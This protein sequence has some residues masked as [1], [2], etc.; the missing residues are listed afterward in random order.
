MS[1]PLL[2]GVLAMLMMGNNFDENV[3]RTESKMFGCISM[4]N[5]DDESDSL[6]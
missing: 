4:A 1:Y 5:A 6:L 3:R 2:T